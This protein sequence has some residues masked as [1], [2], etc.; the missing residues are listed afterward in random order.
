MGCEF[1]GGY[2][3]L[4]VSGLLFNPALGLAEPRRLYRLHFWKKFLSAHTATL[5]SF[6]RRIHPEKSACSFFS[7][8]RQIKRHMHKVSFLGRVPVSFH[9]KLRSNVLL[10]VLLCFTAQ[11]APHIIQVHHGAGLVYCPLN[12]IT[13]LQVVIP[14]L[15]ELL[16]SDTRIKVK[17]HTP[18]TYLYI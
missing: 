17:T 3:I 9:D 16:V 5:R 4:W 8:S 2:G 10:P 11:F 12:H 13:E 1:A 18:I 6:I 14:A 15:V 7:N